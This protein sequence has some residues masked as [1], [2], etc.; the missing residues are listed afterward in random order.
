[1]AIVL[2]DNDLDLAEFAS[3]I[4]IKNTLDERGLSE[5]QMESLIETCN[6]HCFKC[7]LSKEEQEK[8][9]KRIRNPILIKF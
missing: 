5:D 1:V 2:K 7:G 4:R 8:N 9:K 3:S 6:I